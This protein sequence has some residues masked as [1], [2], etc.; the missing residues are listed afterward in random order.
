MSGIGLALAAVSAVSKLKAGQAQAAQYQYMAAGLQSQAKFTRYKGKQESL[1]YFKQANDELTKVLMSMASI[2]A[3]AGAGHMDPFT[4]NPFGL[5]VQALNVGGTNF[6]MAKG[7]EAITIGMANEQANL[8]LHQANQLQQASR[9]AMTQGV[10]GALMSLGKG[11]YDF[12]ET[13]GFGNIGSTEVSGGVP[14]SMKLSNSEQT[15][16]LGPS[17]FMSNSYGGK[18]R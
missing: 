18:P 11:F 14:A 15:N 10:F 16:W 4:G 9:S 12:Y 17:N 6:A 3:A 1:K 5:K 13:G 2:N 8:Q 7:N